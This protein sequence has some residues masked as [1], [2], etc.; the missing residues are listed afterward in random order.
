M[1]GT[2]FQTAWAPGAQQVC[3]VKAGDRA[4]GVGAHAAGPMALAPLV[5]LVQVAWAEGRVTRRERALIRGVARRYGMC[6]RSSEF[7]RLEGWLDFRPPEEFFERHL[8]LH[9]SLLASLPPAEREESRDELLTLCARV[10]EVS[11]G[12]TGF[13]AGGR[14]VCDEEVETV[15][16]IAAVLN[17]R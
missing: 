5:P 7:E 2:D 3:A 8:R 13:A 14:R 11:G 6:E 15:K 4:T 17:G 1:Q 10:A 12:E 16:R 9:G